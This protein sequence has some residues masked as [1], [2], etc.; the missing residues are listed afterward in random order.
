MGTVRECWSAFFSS[1][2]ES[3]EQLEVRAMERGMGTIDRIVENSHTHTWVT[4]RLKPE[5]RQP[6][7]RGG[8]AGRVKLH[9]LCP[10]WRACQSPKLLHRSRLMLRQIW[11]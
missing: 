11:G 5:R 8:T 7:A 1:G 10:P 4:Q 6:R 3:M 2:S 9:R